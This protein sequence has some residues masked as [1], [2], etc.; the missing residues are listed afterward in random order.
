MTQAPD[1]AATPAFADLQGHLDALRTRD[2]VTVRAG[3]EDLGEGLWLSCDPAG[4]TEMTCGPDEAGFRLTVTGADS[5]VWASFG[6]RLPADVLFRGRY[7]GL[8]IEA[9]PSGL[10]SFSPTLRYRFRDGGLQDAG[11]PD[12]VVLPGG[13][14]VHLSHI[15]IDPA[16]AERTGDCELNL[17]F[18]SDAVDMR[19]L[20]MEPL[21]IS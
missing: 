14:Q 17:F 6:M 5:G 16:L 1:A 3:H 7:L 18:H 13:P 20:R 12:P 9:E 19:V 21:L 10:V 4:Q 15:P 8:L 2:P 11:L